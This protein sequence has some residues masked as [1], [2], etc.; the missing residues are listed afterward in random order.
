MARSAAASALTA[1]P[2]IQ[3][4]AQGGAGPNEK[5]NLA[6]IG[7]GNQGAGDID[8]LY[9]SGLCNVVA[10]CDTEIGSGRTKKTLEK[11]PDAPQFTDFR[12]MF[13]KMDKQIDAVLVAT[14]DHSHFVIAMEAMRRGKGVYVEKPL[15]HSFHQIDLLMAAE[16][17][18]KVA[19]QMGNQGHS[20][21]NYFQFKAYSEAGIMKGI[22]KFVAH[23]NGGRR[24]HKWGGDVE[25]IK[26]D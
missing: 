18:Y 12:K 9:K 23:M 13:D 24:W 7:V 5:V 25:K 6:C 2:F 15:A 14:P 26:A 1:F 22:N 4:S 21:G 19:C 16:K 17:K 11:F 20:G 3:A 10:L 8:S